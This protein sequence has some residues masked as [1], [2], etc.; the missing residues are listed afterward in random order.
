M[1]CEISSK[2]GKLHRCIMKDQNIKMQRCIYAEES[3]QK[4]IYSKEPKCKNIDVFSR[5]KI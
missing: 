3:K 5:M 1:Y 2:T 4:M